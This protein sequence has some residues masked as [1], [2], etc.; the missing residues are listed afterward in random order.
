VSELQPVVVALANE[1]VPIL[2]IARATKIPSDELHDLLKEAR[3]QGFILDLPMEDWPR[4]PRIVSAQGGGRLSNFTEEELFRATMMAFGL[5]ACMARIMLML[6]R[7]PGAISYERL[8]DAYN[9]RKTEVAET[10]PKIIDVQVC[11]MRKRLQKYGL[12]IVTEWGFGKRLPEDD[13]LRALEMLIAALRAP[14]V[15][16]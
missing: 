6:I 15:G 13:R 2:A 3:A 10:L 4:P 1:G 16:R 5:T 8:H 11:K 7:L 9:W 14:T 12:E